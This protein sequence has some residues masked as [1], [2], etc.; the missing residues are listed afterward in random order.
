MAFKADLIREIEAHTRKPALSAADIESLA[1]AVC[2]LESLHERLGLLG[3]Y[4][5]CLSA[6]DANNEAVKAEEAALANIEAETVKLSATL[7]SV[8]AQMDAAAF[9]ALKGHAKM[10]QAGFALERMRTEGTRQMSIAEE[11]LAADLNVDGLHAWGRL[12]DTLSG[13][14]SFEMTFPDDHSETVPMA[15]RRALMSEPDRRLREAAFHYGQKP[16][17]DHADTLAAALNGISGSR[18]S[19]YKRRGASHFLEKPLF[20]SAMSREALEAMLEAIHAHIELP[21]RA[22]RKAAQL[23]GTPAL[24]YFDLEAP[25]I[26]APAEDKPLDWAHACA[27]VEQAF[28]AA[29]PK[30]GAYF[31]RMLEHRWIEAQPRA[32]KRPGAFCTGSHL[33]KE[34]RVYMTFHGTI[35]DM[36]TLAHEAGHA[37]HSRVLRP[38]R[39]LA[40]SYPMTLAETASNFGEMILLNG[41]LCDA[42][43]TPQTKAY[44]LDQ[45]ML[46]AHAYLI[47]IPMRYDFENAFYSERSSGELP[48]SRFNELM[49]RSQRKLYGDTLLENGEDP[50]FWASKMHFF[51]SGVSF[52]NFPYVFGYLL[53]QALYARFEAEGPAFLD[54]YE[55]FLEM[56]GSASCEEVVRHSLGEDLTR[57]EFW[58]SA[59]KAMEKPLTAYEAL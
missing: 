1:Q 32:G 12:Y 35:H 2:E 4:L 15:R 45:E 34:E 6:D 18:L 9:E 37:W 43:I 20:D 16:W 42:A 53:S 49:I 29:Y 14:M 55:K 58:S 51:I 46:R 5:G 8:L 19:L 11:S 52:Y 23:Q 10:V 59:L 25:Q 13:K 22:L 47:N 28:S 41:L 48:V 54:S 40:A 50:M 56:T 27:T 38:S 17:I 21:R 24:H 44:L 33:L 30:L 31:R 26:T 39:S 57:P 36:V 3:A 7:Q